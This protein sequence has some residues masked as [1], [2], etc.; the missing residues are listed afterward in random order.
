MSQRTA[1]LFLCLPLELQPNHKSAGNRQDTSM[2]WSELIKDTA[3]VAEDL[4]TQTECEQF[5]E[6]AIEADILDKQQLSDTRHRDSIGVTLDDPEL[7]ERVWNR[8]K[9]H[10]P[11]KVVVEEDCSNAGLV[12]SKK[13]IIGTW[14]P[15]GLN[16]KWRVVC[17][18]GKGHFG[19]HR[20]SCYQVDAHHRS[21][22]TVNGYLTDRPTGYGGATRFLNQDDV[23]VYMNEHGKITSPEDTIL[24]RVEAD[25]AGKAVIFFH[26]HMHDGEPLKEGSPPKWLFRSEVMFERDP[27]TAPKLSKEQMEARE[28]LE[29]AEAAETTG[30]ISEA[31]KLYNRAYRLDPSLEEL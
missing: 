20:D 15:Y 12:N 14:R 21:L 29:K 23:G 13:D 10:I 8:L 17:Y 25:K 11:Q 9:D 3:W 28:Y 26:D 2:K 30:Q 27:D 1:E 22:L 19:P 6:R 24:Y 18:P 5:V 31:I 4:L 7:A 16:F